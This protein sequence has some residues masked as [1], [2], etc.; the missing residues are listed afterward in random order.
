M[1]N[2]TGLSLPY[3]LSNVIHITT[4]HQTVSLYVYMYILVLCMTAVLIILYKYY[5]YTCI[6]YNMKV[7][8]VLCMM[9]VLIHTLY[10]NGQEDYITVNQMIALLLGMIIIL[11]VLII[12][13]V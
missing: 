9:A 12:L 4:K 10:D 2:V 7:V 6:D 11:I 5:Y 3:T 13:Y 1:G 8:L